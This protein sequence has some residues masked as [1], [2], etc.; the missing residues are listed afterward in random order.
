MITQAKL[1]ELKKRMMRHK[2]DN[3]KATVEITAAELQDLIQV[4]EWWFDDCAITFEE[5]DS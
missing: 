3:D 4:A 5:N 1:D 2:T